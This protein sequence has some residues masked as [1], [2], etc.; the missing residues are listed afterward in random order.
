MAPV[1]K[2]FVYPTE[3]SHCEDIKVT[4][5]NSQWWNATGWRYQHWA[6]GLCPVKFNFVNKRDRP[7]AGVEHRFMGIKT[8][9]AALV[10]A[11]ETTYTMHQEDTI[12]HKCFEASSTSSFKTKGITMAGPCPSK[13][14]TVDKTLT[15]TQCPDG[16]TNPRYCTPINVTI[17]TKGE[18]G[19]VMAMT[20][21]KPVYTCGKGPYVASVMVK[22][23]ATEDVKLLYCN[24]EAKHE[25]KCTACFEDIP[26][27][28]D[29]IVSVPKDAQSLL[30]AFK[31]ISGKSQEMYPAAKTG[32]W[33]AAYELKD[34]A[35]VEYSPRSN[36]VRAKVLAAYVKTASN[37]VL[38]HED[39]QNHCTD[40]E[41]DFSADSALNRVKD[42]WSAHKYEYTQWKSGACE[43]KFNHIDHQ[44]HPIGVSGV[45]FRE[46]G[47]TTAMLMK[48]VFGQTSDMGYVHMIETSPGDHCL[49]VAFPGGESSAF[50]KAEGWKYSA[51]VRPEWVQGACDRTKWK[52]VDSTEQSYDGYSGVV[53][54]KFGYN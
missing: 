49:Q 24:H 39:S 54:T 16:V 46:K 3:P 53:M 50:W 6:M 11:V 52:S 25:A 31:D 38:H 45:T 26:Y 17:A 18:A 37:L 9:N 15:V 33:A 35:K 4:D 29:F 32:K 12:D 20:A 14:N 34:A 27:A 43:T 40:L 36:A 22:N 47:M 8:T 44:E 28:H 48:Y 30:F 19:E 41:I 23:T 7:A 10:A 13:Y 21:S 2:H 51:P 1:L 42:W 5:A